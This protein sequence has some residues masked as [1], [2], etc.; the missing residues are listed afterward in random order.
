MLKYYRVC[1]NAYTA[2]IQVSSKCIKTLDQQFY[3]EVQSK[4]DNRQ[5]QQDLLHL[6][7]VVSTDNNQASL[8]CL[9]THMER[10]GDI[11]NRW[12]DSPQQL[13]LLWVSGLLVW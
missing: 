4:A 8:I 11:F 2:Y 6:E 5:V 12:R 3:A 10:E 13:V 9:Q 1:Y 7:V